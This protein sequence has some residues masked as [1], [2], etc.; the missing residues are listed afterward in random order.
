[1]LNTMLPKR[2]YAIEIP[3]EHLQYQR[4]VDANGG[5]NTDIQWGWFV[6]DNQEPTY[7]SL[8]YFTQLNKLRR[9]I[10]LLEIVLALFKP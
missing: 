8:Y 6:N 10:Y 5:S 1:M 9:L 3:F 2:A 4:L 7:S